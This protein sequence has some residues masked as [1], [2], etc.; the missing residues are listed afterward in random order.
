MSASILIVGLP[1]S[2]DELT[3]AV[4]A[5]RALGGRPVVADTE[6]ALGAIRRPE[7]CTYL[8]VAELSVSA[9]LAACGDTRPD[10]V[11][12]ITELTTVLA[13]RVREAF[14]L[15][16]TSAETEAAVTDK[17]RTRSLLR[18]A[19]LTA[20]DCRETSLRD[21][22][23]VLAS[24]D[25][26]V[27]VKPVAFTGSHGVRHIAVPSDADALRDFYD[28]DAA[29]ESGRD[30]L[31]VESVIPGD[32]IS[33]EAV[34][35]NGEV[36]IL[37]LTDKFNTGVPHYYE[38]GHVMPSRHTARWL[39]PV[40]A[41]LQDVVSALKIRTSAL[42]AELMLHDGRVE[43]VE[44]HTRFGGGSIVQLLAEAYG[45]RA[46]DVYF[47]A[48]LRGELPDVPRA[49]G[50]AGV[51]F[52][53]GWAGAPFRWHSYDFPC[54]DAV[55]ALSLDARAQ[56]KVRQHEGIRLG[57]W[58]TGRAVFRASGADGYARVAANVAFVRDQFQR[59][60]PAARPQDRP[61]HHEGTHR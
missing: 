55:L 39:D 57:Y 3:L 4:E 22:P 51:A 14:A 58:R 48:L 45:V 16:G 36:R 53:G 21:L 35:V 2:Q 15:P 33:A 1:W 60:D 54:A 49:T 46:Y 30:R 52:F 38:V 10:H 42:H 29:A 13:A 32:E 9:V 18:A 17:F 26:P 25:L 47:T 23:A 41:Y 31:I 28:A 43:L 7:G 12:S 59:L 5:V 61:S 19:G 34:C 37:G 50:T 40:R 44:L 11:V 20:V 27:V 6:Q 8:P 56:P 24:V